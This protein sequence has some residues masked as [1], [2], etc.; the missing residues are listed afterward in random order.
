LRSLLT[1]TEQYHLG[2][3]S[4]VRAYPV[5]EFLM[6]SAF[7]ASMEWTADWPGLIGQPSPFKNL[8]WDDVL[9][10]SFFTDFATG[11]IQAPNP[12][13]EAAIAVAGYGFGLSF[14]LPGEFTGRFQA[15][16]RF[17]L[18]HQ[19]TDGKTVHYGFD[20]SYAF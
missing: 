1:S 16:H 17:Q 18:N 5:S 13:D 2:G 7:F 20:F 4:H 11:T 14:T 12:N 6:D 8:N 9:H 19:Q 10:V 3:P 15:S